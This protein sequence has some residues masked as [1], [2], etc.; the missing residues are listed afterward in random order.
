MLRLQCCSLWFLGGMKMSR[1]VLRPAQILGAIAAAGLTF[2]ASQ[3]LAK[4]D[5]AKEPAC[6]S[7]KPTSQGG[8][9][10]INRDLLVIRWLGTANE[11]FAFRDQVILHDAYYSQYAVPPARP[12]GFGA[13]DV[14]KASVILISHGHID[15]TQDVPFL[16]KKLGVNAVGAPVTGEILQKM[17]MPMEHFVSVTGKGGEMLTYG[18]V[19]VQPLLG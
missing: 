8:P 3:A 17:G 9:A 12:L 2:T 16:V 13:Q 10:P 5:F 19:K 1:W 6:Q 4:V 7:D 18:P 15:H 14:Q 11:E